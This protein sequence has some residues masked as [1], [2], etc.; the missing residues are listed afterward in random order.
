MVFE[1]P[2]YPLDYLMAHDVTIAQSDESD[3]R[4]IIKDILYSL[5]SG[6]LV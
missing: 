4:D 5:Q 1:S 6:F 3:A 2:H